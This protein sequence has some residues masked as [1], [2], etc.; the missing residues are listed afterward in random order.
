MKKYIL[1][2]FILLFISNLSAQEMFLGK[3]RGFVL[4]TMEMLDAKLLLSD[5]TSDGSYRF[6]VFKADLPKLMF[7]YNDK[8]SCVIMMKV[9]G[10]EYLKVAVD[11]LNKKYIRYGNNVWMTQDLKV[12]INL[13]ISGNE[14]SVKYDLIDPP[15]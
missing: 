13:R 1:T 6:D 5:V 12:N 3:E 9:Y 15:S 11:D 7:Y 4:K 14:F 8:D 10:I 2:A